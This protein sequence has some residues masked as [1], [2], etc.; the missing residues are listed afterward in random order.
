MW[1]GTNS[2]SWQ[3]FDITAPAVLS[4]VGLRDATAGAGYVEFDDIFVTEM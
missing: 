1:T 4:A 3:Y 2:T